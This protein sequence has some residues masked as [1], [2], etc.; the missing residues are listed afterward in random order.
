[1]I[2]YIFIL[3]FLQRAQ[4]GIQGNPSFPFIFASSLWSRWVR[5][6]DCPRSVNQASWPSRDMNLFPK[7]ESTVL[8]VKVAVSIKQKCAVLQ[9]FCC[10]L[11]MC[12]CRWLPIY[13][14]LSICSFHCTFYIF[15]YVTGIP[16][17]CQFSLVHTLLSASTYVPHSSTCRV[18]SLHRLFQ[19]VVQWFI[20]YIQ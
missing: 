5:D 20:L 1:M 2:Y 12:I 7:S 17:P 4:G 14:A 15:L 3:P 9:F 18:H 6:S 8:V 13:V 16:L 19:R 11:L 10:Y